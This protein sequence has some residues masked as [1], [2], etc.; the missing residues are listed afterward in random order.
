MRDLYATLQ[1]HPLA[2]DEVIRA[3]YRTLARKYHPD[4]GGDSVRMT[5]INDAW[6]VLG[7]P[8]RRAA[9]D[10]TRATGGSARASATAHPA[11]AAGFHR[12]PE[13][14]AEAPPRSGPPPGQERESSVK[15]DPGA[16]RPVDPGHMGPPPGRPSG[17]V[18]D[19]G[20]YAGWSLG[21]IGRLDRDYL[22]WLSRSTIGRGLRSE[23]DALLKGQTGAGAAGDP[24]A[25]SR[26]WPRR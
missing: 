14:S 1:V 25:A 22:E 11:T 8:A 15:Y 16:P 24:P 20:R 17:S 3:A 6:D 23:L 21:E 9:Y 13:R 12:S 19:F 7:D 26:N 5:Q 4:H 2:E 18:L 10:A